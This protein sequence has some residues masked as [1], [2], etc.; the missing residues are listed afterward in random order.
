MKCIKQYCFAGGLRTKNEITAFRKQQPLKCANGIGMS[1]REHV[2]VRQRFLADQLRK[3]QG[4]KQAFNACL[5]PEVRGENIRFSPRHRGL[6]CCTE[7]R[8][9]EPGGSPDSAPVETSVPEQL[10]RRVRESISP[11][12][13]Q[14]L[15]LLLVSLTS[16][17]QILMFSHSYSGSVRAGNALT[18]VRAFSGLMRQEILRTPTRSLGRQNGHIRRLCRRLILKPQ[19]IIL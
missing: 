15:R 1:Q 4:R 9:L 18:P 3:R 5:Q 10:G 16:F 6:P 14:P 12:D 8:R 2:G 19:I 13:S 7:L 17:G 11:A